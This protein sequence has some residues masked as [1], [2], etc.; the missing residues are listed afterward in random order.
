MACGAAQWTEHL[1]ERHLRKQHFWRARAVT[2][3]SLLVLTFRAAMRIHPAMHKP[4]VVLAMLLAVSPAYAQF[5]E[6]KRADANAAMGVF[7][8]AAT[9][10]A[11]S[12][13]TTAAADSYSVTATVVE[14]RGTSFSIR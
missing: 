12:D 1:L 14:Y 4:M 2:E 8:D 7:D 11:D 5:E 6:D 13:A 3:T 9:T 10:A